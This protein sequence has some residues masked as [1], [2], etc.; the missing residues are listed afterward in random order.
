MK[1]YSFIGSDKNAGKTTALN[2]I[3]RGLT[4]EM[5]EDRPVCLTSIGINGESVDTY[6]GREKPSIQVS[7]N[8]LF[9]TAGEHLGDLKGQYSVLHVFAGP[10]FKKPFVLARS[11]TG[12]PVVLEGPNER[13][14]MIGVK[15]VI[16][17]NAEQ[18]I[19]LIDGSID[20]QFVGQPDISDGI[21]F[22]LLMTSRKEQQLKAKGLL[23][24]LT[25]EACTRETA[26]R[27]KKQAS[28]G[29]KSLLLNSAGDILFKGDGV[30][31]LDNRLREICLD[32]AGVPT[33][34][35]LRGA[36]TRSLHQF[37]AP[38]KKLKIVLD[39]F[40]LYQN[41]TTHP[42]GRER[43]HPELL[44]YHS[45]QLKSIFLKQDGLDLYFRLPPQIPSFNLFRD[46]PHEIG[47]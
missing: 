47:I 29:G 18:G 6:E 40:T 11:Q 28:T 12:F 17:R 24:A 14:G 37:F 23:F 4:R 38:F 9:V 10:D 34:L 2:F 33:V 1:T 39:N 46:D 8:T 41:I 43:F 25:L 20:R 5:T 22:A 26:E 44:L 31:A 42:G 3:Y 21:C 36:L 15:E 13:T 45:V 27:I 35:Y 32:H 19:C 30:P 7:E 16:R